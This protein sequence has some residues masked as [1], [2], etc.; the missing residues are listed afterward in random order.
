MENKIVIKQ[1]TKWHVQIVLPWIKVKQVLGGLH[2]G[3][4]G[5][6]L[7]SKTPWT[8]SDSSTTGYM[9][10]TMLKGGANNVTP[11]SQDPCTKR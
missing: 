7:G 3:S 11:A 5:G 10:G 4:L 9:Q 8:R 2:G 1:H 6:H